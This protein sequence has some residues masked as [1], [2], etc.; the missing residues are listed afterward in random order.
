MRTAVALAFLCLRAV[1]Q[2]Q[3]ACTLRGTV[4]DG[5][6][7]KPM[8]RVRV[9]AT[10]VAGTSILKL[11]DDHG[12]FCFPNLAPGTYHLY[13][14]K[15]G[16]LAIRYPMILSVE[17]DTAIHPLVI[18]ME[19][20]GTISGIVTD[21][22]GDV[23]PDATV[24][25]W[26]RTRAG[27]GEV[28]STTTDSHGAFHISQLPEGTYYLSA[29][30]PDSDERRVPL[31]FFD[32][33]GQPVREREL[34]TYY[35][36]SFT[37]AGAAPVKLAAGQQIENLTLSL[38]KA[39]LRRLSGQI[40]DVPRGAHLTCY[41]AS[42][43]V[44][45][46]VSGDIPISGSGAF[47]RSA[48]PPGRYIV[49]LNVSDKLIAWKEVDLTLGDAL[50]VTLDPVEAVDIPIVFR[51]EG[52]APA[53]QPGSDVLLVQSGS[54]FG[55]MA[56]PAGAGTY[57][58]HNV[59]PGI[60]QL[61]ASLAD[62]QLYLKAITYGGKTQT[63]DK[64]DL[65][66]PGQGPLEITLSPNIAEIQ[67]TVELLDEGQD[68]TVVLADSTGVVAQTGTDQKGRFRMRA[69]PP[70]KYQLLAIE[71]FDPDDWDNAELS[72]VVDGKSLAIELQENDRKQVTVPATIR[73]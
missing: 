9:A 71:D 39:R 17:P 54:D 32:A 70:G 46:D 35:P 21:S 36:V 27:H 41:G 68:V 65:R 7:N 55:A 22:E 52:K 72:K 33:G 45:S 53:F 63:A 3:G 13:A 58:F 49:S 20:Y 64:I 57:R 6:R 16:Y 69:I 47:S 50:N 34:A 5:A 60:Y 12:S 2:E 10:D 30:P 28:D 66:S 51:V 14:Q 18:R 11:T 19:R 24:T 15:P 37:L 48:L 1:A 62:R 26:Q 8:E 4:T 61:H 23:S 42:E 25:I 67:G 29:A 40:A 44:P 38:R 73:N 31:L 43:D 59:I 56:Q